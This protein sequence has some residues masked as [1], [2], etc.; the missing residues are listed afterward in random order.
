MTAAANASVA[1]GVSPNHTQSRHPRLT[2]SPIYSLDHVFGGMSAM[3]QRGASSVRLRACAGVFR[4]LLTVEQFRS[5]TGF[6]KD[7]FPAQAGTS[8]RL[9]ARTISMPPSRA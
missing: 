8:P 2:G 1:R 3:G 4:F 6:P 7:K 9:T 5:R